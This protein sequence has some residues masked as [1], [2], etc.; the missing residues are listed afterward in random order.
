M[1]KWSLVTLGFLLLTVTDCPSLL[2]IKS[3]IS[4]TLSIYLS[5]LLAGILQGL[6]FNV[7]S[8]GFICTLKLSPCLKNAGFK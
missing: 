2:S 4:N 3:S 7:R 5:L 1:P 8:E 6:A